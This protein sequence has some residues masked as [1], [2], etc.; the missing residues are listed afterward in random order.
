MNALLEQHRIAHREWV[1]VE[2]VS[3]SVA[4]TDVGELR[5]SER[6]ELA[7]L[8]ELTKSLR[9]GQISKVHADEKMTMGGLCLRDEV[10]HFGQV[11]R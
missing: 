2:V 9:R 7:T 4:V 11:L 8:H 1:V 6:S 3:P 10:G 5:I